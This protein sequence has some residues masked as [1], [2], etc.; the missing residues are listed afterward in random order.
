MTRSLRERWRRAGPSLML[1][2][3]VAV[4]ALLLYLTVRNVDLEMFRRAVR[5]SS[6]AWFV[7]ALAALAVSVGV[8]VVRW[9]YLFDPATRP[10]APA[11]TRAL[12]VGELFNCVVPL[13]GGDVARV[14]VLHRDAGTSRVEAGATVV[15]ERLLDTVVLLL[16]V[17]ATLPF[18]PDVTWL[19]T[20]GAVLAVAAAGLL[21]VVVVLHLFGSRP[22]VA[23]AGLLAP[24]SGA[25]VAA[26]VASGVRAFRSLGAGALAVVLTVAT[27]LAV[28]AACW[29]VL[30]AVHVELGYDAGVLIAAATTFALVIPSAPASIGVFEAAVLVALRPYGVGDARALAYA[31]VLHVVTFAPFIVAGLV[32]LRPLP[33]GFGAAVRSDAAASRMRP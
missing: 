32:A 5:D 2:V 12:L 15:A 18:A 31:V 17:F 13:R 8:R 16:L 29:F 27:W 24:G 6:P 7:P 11:A 1:V 23:V 4:S 26:R 19:G 14:L 25:E 21:V 22:L 28:G 3:G 10:S 20:A 30:Q 33:K 9:R